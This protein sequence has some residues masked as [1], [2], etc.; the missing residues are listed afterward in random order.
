MK[1]LCAFVA[2]CMVAVV[3]AAEKPPVARV[4]DDAVASGCIAGVVSVLSDADCN[5]RFDCAGWAVAEDGVRRA[6]ASDTLFAVFSMTKT[7]TGAAVMCA[8]D[9]GVISLDDPVSKYLPEFADVRM[10]DGTRPKR[11]PNVRDLM[12]H[13]TG[14]RG[15]AS[16]VDRDIPLREVARRLAAMPLSFQPGETFAYGNAW[17]CAAAA[18]LEVATG[19]AFENYLKR[20]ILDPL[21]M[22]D[23]TFAPTVAQQRRLARAYTS[24][25]QAFRPGNDRCTPQLTFPKKNRV[26][27]AASG[28]LFSTPSDMIRF[29]QML[30]HHGEWHGERI[31]SRRTFDTV[32]AVKQTPD[33]IAQPYTVGSWL[34]GDWFGHEGAMRTDQRANLRTGHCRVF[35]IQ[36]E[37]K[38]GSAFFKLKSE[39]HAA[40]DREQGTP[41]VVFGN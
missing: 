17:V 16:V 26:Y 4:L 12:S 31:I 30:A 2:V 6:M 25:G 14:W 19:E 37:N 20:R 10:A 9:D 32:F 38:A 18:C 29:S 22:S 5:V 33:G 23:T 3:Q 41:A 21:G 11:A 28:G 1:S 39:W 13:M 40:A 35:F 27:P 15:G 7:F 8:I 24:D 36:T 34:Y